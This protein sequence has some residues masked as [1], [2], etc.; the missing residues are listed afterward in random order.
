MKIEIKTNKG[1]FFQT[2]FSFKIVL[3]YLFLTY[4]MEIQ[5]FHGEVYSIQ[6]YVMKFVNDLR[7]VGGFPRVLRFSPPIKR[8]STI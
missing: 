1:D 8:T 7:Q 3:T 4:S 2:V 5:L 6:H